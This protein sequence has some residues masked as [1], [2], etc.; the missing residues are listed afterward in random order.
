MATPTAYFLGID[1][2]RTGLGL[3]VLAGT[4]AQ[5]ANLHRA[6]GGDKDVVDVGHQRRYK[7]KLGRFPVRGQP[8]AKLSDRNVP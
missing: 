6:Y 8:T 2:A 3:V 1:V 4:G 7:A 5:V